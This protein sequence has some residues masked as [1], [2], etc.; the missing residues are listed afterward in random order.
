MINNFD[1]KLLTTIYDYKYSVYKRKFI[2]HTNCNETLSL[3]FP[4]KFIIDY[5]DLNNKIRSN[6]N[7]YYNTLPEL[8]SAIH[9]GQMC[10]IK[11]SDKDSLN[12]KLE[13]LKKIVPI[14]LNTIHSLI[15]KN[16][17]LYVVLVS[18]KGNVIIEFENHFNDNTYEATD[19]INISFLQELIE[20]SNTYVSIPIKS[21]YVKYK[22]TK[23]EKNEV[24]SLTKEEEKERILLLREFLVNDNNNINYEDYI[25][26]VHIFKK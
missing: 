4:K 7:N 10:Q 8:V 21:E 9:K 12:I 26:S 25:D 14:T 3:Y 13:E 15:Y 22:G 18:N 20:S 11:K 6:N 2:L 5:L 16:N 23:D 19:I 1:K 24:Y 17:K